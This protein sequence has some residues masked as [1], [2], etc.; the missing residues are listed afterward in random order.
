[1][2]LGPNALREPTPEDK[3]WIQALERVVDNS[4]EFFAFRHGE[5][6]VPVKPSDLT[7]FLSSR[8]DIRKAEFIKRYNQAGWFSVRFHDDG[9]TFSETD[10]S[11]GRD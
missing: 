3:H 7:E 9:I 1:M 5:V 10:S 2:A 8:G 11:E 6:T 4:P